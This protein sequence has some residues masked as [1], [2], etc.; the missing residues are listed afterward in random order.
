MGIRTR[1]ELRRDQAGILEAYRARRAETDV[2][3]ASGGDGGV[4]AGTIGKV[5][6]VV[7]SDPTLGAHLVVQPQVF[8]GAPATASDASRPVVITY[9]TPNH[10][11]GDYSV[12][13]CV[14]LLTVRGAV[15]AGKLG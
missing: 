12:D 3:E 11:V 10:V 6:S 2:V 15:L 1:D 14:R 9:P 13:E 8:S 4:V 5:T 7:T